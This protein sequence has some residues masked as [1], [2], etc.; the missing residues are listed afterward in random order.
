[1]IVNDFNFERIPIPPHE[2]HAVLVVHPDAV[3]PG[4]AAAKGFQPVSRRNSKVIQRDRRVQDCKFL[5]GSSRKTRRKA[6][7]SAGP[8]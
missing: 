4:A 3:L 8:P 5:E 2:A 6:S 7:A 1:M